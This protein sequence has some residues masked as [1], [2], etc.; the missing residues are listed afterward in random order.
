[1][2]KIIVLLT[3]VSAFS[4]HSFAQDQSDGQSEPNVVAGATNLG[5]EGEPSSI[6][7]KSI[8]DKIRSAWAGLVAG[9]KDKLAPQYHGQGGLAPEGVNQETVL[10]PDVVTNPPLD[11]VAE[12]EVPIPGETNAGALVV[13]PTADDLAVA[14]PDIINP[15]TPI[16]VIEPS[17]AEPLVVPEKA[18]PR[19]GKTNIADS[20]TSGVTDD[21]SVGMPSSD[22]TDEPTPR[23][24]VIAESISYLHEDGTLAQVSTEDFV[25]SL[26]LTNDS[27][28]ISWATS[29]NVLK[30]GIIGTAVWIVWAGVRYTVGAGISTFFLGLGLTSSQAQEYCSQYDGDAGLEHFRNLPLEE[31]VFEA[32]ACPVLAGNVMALARSVR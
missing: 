2:K 6:K 12:I 13:D 27:E 14:E 29:E 17:T 3:V 1:M 16:P 28:I 20:R 23:E 18:K 7:N 24:M 26:I 30:V 15:V 25:D 10:Q 5:V 19:R 11:P 8:M 4:I 21:P 32:N 9:V 22:G 31:Q